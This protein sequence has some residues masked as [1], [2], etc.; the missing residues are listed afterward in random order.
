MDASFLHLERP[1]QQLNVGSVMVFEGPAPAF[2]EVWRAVESLLARVPR[3]RQR[4]RH[5]PLELGRPVWADDPHFEL[6]A[7][8]GHR[9][10]GAPGGDRALRSLAVGL[11]A[12]P[13][14]LDRSPWRTWQVT[15][16]RG[17]RWALV[18]TNHHAM[19]DGI[20]GTDIMAVLLQPTAEASL[21]LAVPSPWEP[22]PDPS[23]LG[24]LSGALRELAADPLEVARGTVRALTPC[25]VRAEL[26]GAY[27]LARM[28]EHLAWPEFGLAGPLGQRRR[29]EWA[30]ADL[31]D[32]KRVKNL[33]GGTVNDVVLSVTA[34]GFRRLLQSR[35]QAVDATAT[36]RTMVPVSTRHT[37][38]HGT[39][40][41]RV[42][43]VFADLPVGIADP[44]Q[45]LDAVTAQLSS[46][47][48]SGEAL[49]VDALLDAA[50]HVPAA[51]FALGV[52]TW[53]HVPQRMV[54]TVTTNV[55]GPRAPLYLLGRRMTDI[56]PYIPLGA[57]V[58]V[59][60]GIASYA[61]RLTWGLTGDF[62]SVPDLGV[63]A[64]GIDAS[65][66]E[67]CSTTDRSEV[68]HARVQ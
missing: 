39:L 35:G 2:Q 49:G 59:T 12:A 25:R 40:G 55:P 33:R 66:R 64:Q 37:D 15:G 62:E 50:D 1:V 67:L 14:D 10:L 36:V 54:S 28:G 7:H 47:K 22:E 41:N 68:H 18:N 13:L 51:L 29:W 48:T 21:H 43:A 5:V 9:R 16:L 6:A 57:Q 42:S 60:V 17:G 44:V 46:L 65:V 23:R 52:R 24:L 20:S 58:R 11:I 38:E 61:G 34:G 26:A 27:G 30:C 31:E 63:L 32:V 56:Y 45:R 19:I 4:I 3:Y 53:A 8:L